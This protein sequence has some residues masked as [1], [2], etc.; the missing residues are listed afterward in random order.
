MG[1]LL[2]MLSLNETGTFDRCTG[3]RIKDPTNPGRQ[4]IEGFQDLSDHETTFAPSYSGRISAVYTLNISENLLVDIEPNVYFTDSYFI[5]QDFDPF[6]EQDS[7]AM[8]GLRVGVSNMEGDWELAVIG[9]NLNNEKTIF[10]ANDQPAG[11]G[12]YVRSLNRPRSWAVQAR[13]N[14]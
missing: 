7:Y 13:Y 2:N 14:F 12:S 3:T 10:F 11:G 8:W 6:T 1:N 5:Q 4:I 9:K